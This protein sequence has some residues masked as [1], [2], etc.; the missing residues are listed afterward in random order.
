[1]CNTQKHLQ[2]GMCKTIDLG[3]VSNEGT[4]GIPRCIR[5]AALGVGGTPKINR[6]DRQPQVSG[7]WKY[8]CLLTWGQAKRRYSEVMGRI[9][10]LGHCT[11]CSEVDHCQRVLH[12]QR[13]FYIPHNSERWP[14]FDK[15]VDPQAYAETEW[16][17]RV[18]I[19]RIAISRPTLLPVNHM[20][21]PFI[22]AELYCAGISK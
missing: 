11:K 18:S 10:V 9:G 7:E 2:F 1:M 22:A 13:V 5:Q 20:S 8:K 21:P 3:P 17:L 16:T 19:W 14:A 15:P 4:N 6:V 12:P